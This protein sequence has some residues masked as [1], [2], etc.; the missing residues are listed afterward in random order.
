MQNNNV[1]KNKHTGIQQSTTEEPFVWTDANTK[2]FLHL[3][4]D[5]ITHQKIR[6]KKILWRKLSEALQ[7]HNYNAS[8]AQV[9]NKFKSLERSYKTMI[10]NN[11]KTGRNRISCSYE[12]YVN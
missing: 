2:L 4:K 3:Y 6:I 5:A 10:T 9:E 11:K 7:S 12:T 8:A 1:I